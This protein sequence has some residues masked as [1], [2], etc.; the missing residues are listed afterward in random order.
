MEHT[1]KKLDLELSNLGTKLNQ[2]GDTVIAQ[3]DSAL[4][5]LSEHDVPGA[6]V[7]IERDINVNQMDIDLEEI[8]MQLLALHQPVAGD[9]RGS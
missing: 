8:C 5:C 3:I 2:M 1:H 7:I 6:R 4:G 9:L